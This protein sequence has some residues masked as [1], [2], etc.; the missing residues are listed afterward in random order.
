MFGRACFKCR[1]CFHCMS[2]LEELTKG[3]EVT[4]QDVNVSCEWWGGFEEE[5]FK[6]R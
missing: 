3:R 5:D 4:E 1:K 6:A 2:S